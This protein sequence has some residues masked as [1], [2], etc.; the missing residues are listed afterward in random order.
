MSLAAAGASASYTRLMAE[1][2]RSIR[3]ISSM[4]DVLETDL[5][6][7]LKGNQAV[8]PRG[9]M[10]QLKEATA[11]LNSLTD[12]KVR[13]DKSAKVLSDALTPEQEEEACRSY[14]RAMA[15]GKRLRFIESLS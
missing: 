3:I 11:C 5:N 8:I 9:V 6:E 10:T 14:V 15:P 7:G 1:V 12:A 2:E 13:L 4:L